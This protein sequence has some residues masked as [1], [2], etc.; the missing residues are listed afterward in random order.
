MTA[1]IRPATE[2]DAAAVAAIYAPYVRDTAVSF[3]VDAP[4]AAE[5][6]QRIARTLPQYPW[7]V[8][9]RG[10]EVLG[11]AYG[12]QFRVRAAYQWSVEV[13]V[14]VAA[15]AHRHGI[16]RALYTAL[17]RLLVLQGYHRAYAGITLPNPASIGLHESLGFTRVA[18]YHAVGFKRGAWHDV[19]SWELSL[20]PPSLPSGPPLPFD[21]IRT[22]PD[23]EAALAAGVSLLRM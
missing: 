2:D 10:P 22:S 17:I 6:R 8:C 9:A 12:S 21:S 15:Q 14:Y 7:L 20:Q 11:Y 23:C 19:G 4:A 18:L 5:M 16:G 3:E 1:T 13:T